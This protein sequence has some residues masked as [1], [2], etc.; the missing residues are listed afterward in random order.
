MDISNIKSSERIIE[1]LH[2]K[3][4]E[5]LGISVT[6]MSYDDDRMKKIRRKILDRRL[7]LEARGKHFKSE[8]LNENANDLCF[9]AM[10]GWEWRGDAVFHGKKPEFTRASVTA[11]FEELS[12]F[13][14]QIDNAIGD[15]KAF[16]A[17]S[18]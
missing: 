5:E 14:D 1:I 17:T 8:E 9:N 6:V 4:G 13:R 10:T 18:N 3:T 11:V 7:H 16:F 2:P 12:W 15:E